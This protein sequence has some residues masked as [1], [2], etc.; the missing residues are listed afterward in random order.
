[1]LVLPEGNRA[2][3]LHVAPGAVRALTE[4]YEV[5]VIV[6]L[7]TLGAGAAV[8]GAAVVEGG[9]AVGAK[10]LGVFAAV[11]WTE[12]ARVSG[13]GAAAALPPHE[14]TV[15]AESTKHRISRT[16]IAIPPHPDR[17]ET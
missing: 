12:S 6:T 8:E 15:H 13:E 17:L 16:G 2:D 3:A 14:A 10:A 7:R 9:G 4:P 11:V 5:R 1:M